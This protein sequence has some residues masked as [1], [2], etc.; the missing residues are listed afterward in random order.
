MQDLGTSYRLDSELENL[1]ITN[2][3]LKFMVRKTMEKT[4]QTFPECD[5]HKL[6][7]NRKEWVTRYFFIN[8]CKGNIIN[9]CIKEFENNIFNSEQ[10]ENFLATCRRSVPIKNLELGDSS[11]SD[12]S[13]PDISPRDSGESPRSKSLP[14][15]QITA[16]YEQIKPKRASGGFIPVSVNSK[17]GKFKILEYQGLSVKTT[18]FKYNILLNKCK[19]PETIKKQ[20]LFGCLFRYELIS[21]NNFHLA[22][23]P[24]VVKLVQFEC[25]GSPFNSFNS[26]N[27]FVPYFSAFPEVD[28]Y[29]GSLGD[30]FID[31]IPSDVN[32]ISFNPPYDEEIFKIAVNRLILQMICRKDSV[33]ELT[34]VATLPVWDPETQDKYNFYK[35]KKFAGKNFEALNILKESGLIKEDRVLTREEAP[36]YDYITKTYVTAVNIH[37]IIL[38]TGKPRLTVAQILTQWNRK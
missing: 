33:E 18:E 1:I 14:E 19:A 25:F 35:D 38:C 37:L 3:F 26:Y 13:S 10:I 31:L 12:D 27:G 7:W 24:N 5:R 20:V 2:M 17:G 34:V 23:P 11:S 9:F 6:K 32:I 4:L 8:L 15:F 21:G 29:F 22:I 30:Y 16:R 36:F 28:R